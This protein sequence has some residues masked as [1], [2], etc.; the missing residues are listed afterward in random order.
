MCVQ[1]L[2]LTSHNNFQLKLANAEKEKAEL[3]A[4]MVE[5]KAKQDSVELQ[6][7][8]DRKMEEKIAELGTNLAEEMRAKLQELVVNPIHKQSCSF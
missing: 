6:K 1:I 4:E 8:I 2:T 7:K 3:K 5:M